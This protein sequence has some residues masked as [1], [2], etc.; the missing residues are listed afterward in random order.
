VASTARV[1]SAAVLVGILGATIWLLPA[2]TTV[3]LA[4]VTA[5]LAGG[6]LTGLFRR[7]GDV[8][9]PVFVGIAAALA[10]AAFA[11]VVGPRPGSFSPHLLGSVL[12]A[13]MIG[14]GLLALASGSPSPAALNR[15]A[16]VA[17]AMT[18]VGLPLGTAAWIRGA[19]GPGALTWLLAVIALSDSAQYFT[20]RALGRRKLAPQVSPAKTV[21]GAIG[22][23]VVAALA[24]GL[25]ARFWLPVLS[26]IGAA[27]CALVL[28][29]FG[30]AGDLFESLLKRS[31]GVKD[32]SQLIPGHGGVL[33]RIDAYLFAAPAFYFWLTS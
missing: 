27:G 21:E 9:S 23:L 32:S 4:A 19:H 5:A 14:A 18:Y 13:G 30:I 8:P 1:L 24:G 25:L 6:E 12:L 2:W 16:V 29:V 17:L 33:D 28:A 10:C 31:A 3:V 20:G 15:P 22:G 7:L 11:L 26:P